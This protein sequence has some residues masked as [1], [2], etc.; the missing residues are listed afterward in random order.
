MDG[1]LALKK[2]KV[3]ERLEALEEG[4]GGGGY[5]LPVAS[6]ETLGG[7][8]IGENLS[9]TEEGVLSAASGVVDYSTTEQATGQKWID[10]KA[11]YRKVVTNVA[12]EAII[13]TNVDTIVNVI[14]ARH[15]AST[16]ANR[17][18]FGDGFTINDG[19][20]IYLDTTTHEAQYAV[21]AS[22]GGSLDKP[23][24]HIIIEYTKV[25]ATRKKK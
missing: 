10:G 16:D 18:V 6:D 14:I 23:A 7:V 22:T 8:K 13:A 3:V 12:N 21:W 17:H 2:Y 4:G 1:T 20:S 15:G 19:G 9:I 11:I 25:E 24:D 5:V